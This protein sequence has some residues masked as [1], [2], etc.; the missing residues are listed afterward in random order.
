MSWQRETEREKVVAQVLWPQE[1]AS[2][3]FQ[4]RPAS[5]LVERREMWSSVLFYGPREPQ[6]APNRESKRVE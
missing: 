6:R 1:G 3:N 2:L 5:S 4:W